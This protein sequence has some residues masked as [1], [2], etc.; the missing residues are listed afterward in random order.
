M[1]SILS[2]NPYSIRQFF[3]GLIISLSVIS[4]VTIN[5]YFP[6]AAAEEAAEKI[7]DEVL[8]IDTDEAKPEPQS[9]Y[10]SKPN[11]FTLEKNF[12]NTFNNNTFIISIID[13]FIPVAHA[14][15]ANISIETAKIR[16]IRNSMGKR[17][18]KLRPFYQ[19]G[20]IGFTNNGLI[21]ITG[22]KGLSAKQK[23]TANKL[24]KA[25]NNDRN[26]LYKEIANANGHPEWQSDIQKTFS[27]TWINKI[28][29][30]W[31]Y[32]TSSGKWQKK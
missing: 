19:S 12:N 22:V 5:I 3:L 27:H 26:K 1:N 7:V 2:L 6:A 23:S 32:Q 8:N 16:S 21:A 20:A 17:Q 28:S 11:N 24:I 15:Q 30:G 13:L 18:A 4:C 14:A 9:F 29:A 10:Q 25:E 31:M